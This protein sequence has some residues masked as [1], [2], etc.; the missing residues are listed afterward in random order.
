MKHKKLFISLT[1]ILAVFVF[2]GIFLLMWFVGDTY[3]DFKRFRKEFEIEGLDDGAVPQGIAEYYSQYEILDENGNST[4]KYQHYFLTSAYMKDGSPSRIYV[5]GSESGYIGSVT[6]LNEDGTP[7]VGHVGGIATNS[8]RLW[9]TY[10][11]SILVAQ[12]SEEYKNDNILKEIIAKATK[13]SNL[14]DGEEEQ[15]I[16]FTA[17]FKANCNAAYLYYYHDPRYTTTSYDRLY[18][19][20]FYRKGNYETDK[21]HRLETPNGYKNTSFMYEYK[22]NTSTS[23][24]YGLDLIDSSSTPDK[25]LSD[26]V[27]KI[28]KIYSLPEKIQG[29]AFSGRTGY[30]TTTGLLILSQSY[31]LANSHLLCFDWSKVN[32]KST[33]YTDLSENGHSFEYDGVYRTVSS[34]KKSPYSDKDL[35]VYYVDEADGE[36]FVN[37]YSVPSMSEG[38]CTVTLQGSSTA[39]QERVYVL[40]ESGCKKYNLFTRESIKNIYSFIPKTK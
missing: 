29:I 39:T 6:M 30:G 24:K 13:N 16:Q 28:Q 26:N 11:D 10:G 8:T 25:T 9:V 40:F 7:H 36:M 23:N 38:M 22:T 20:E 32:A 18:V 4:K 2:F 27:P 1:A 3:P 34:D 15:S 35:L 17:S 33:K 21:S 12:A 5:T 31:G 14:E 37:D 19:G